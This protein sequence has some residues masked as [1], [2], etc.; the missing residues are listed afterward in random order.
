MTRPKK[1]KIKVLYTDDP[2]KALFD[3]EM[4]IK[5]VSTKYKALKVRDQLIQE[6]MVARLEFNSNID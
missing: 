5:Y 2:A 4:E 6:G 1:Q 3:D